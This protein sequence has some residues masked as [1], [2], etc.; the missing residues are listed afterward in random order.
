MSAILVQADRVR[1]AQPVKAPVAIAYRDDG[2]AFPT[3][4]VHAHWQ[5]RKGEYR[6]RDT[7]TVE[8]IPAADGRGF[9]LHRDPVAV[10]VEGPDADA[11][12]GVLVARNGQDHICSCRGF[13]A[14]GRCK[15]HDAMRGLVEA[16]HIDHPLHDPRPDP[17]I[18]NGEE[19][20]F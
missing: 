6:D 5:P 2:K 9:M 15:H 13:A 16:G 10:V 17:I 8:E 19:A 11:Y 18:F 4:T 3:L 7:Y 1:Q 20:P 12:Y 14:H